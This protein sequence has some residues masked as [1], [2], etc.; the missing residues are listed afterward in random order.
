MIASGDEQRGVRNRG[1]HRGQR[2]E[3]E[4]KALVSSPFAEGE[5]AKFAGWAQRGTG[6]MGLPES[7]VRTDGDVRCSIALMER[8]PIALQQDRHRVGAQ[9]QP[10]GESSG[11]V[12]KAGKG[13][14]RMSQ[15]AVLHQVVE[16]DVGPVSRGAGKRRR[17]QAYKGG[18]SRGAERRINE[19]E[20]YDLRLDFTQGA[21]DS[22]RSAHTADAPTAANVEAIKLRQLRTLVFIAKDRK[23][24]AVSPEFCSKMKSIFAEM[25][26][27]WR[28]GCDQSDT[29]GF[30]GRAIKICAL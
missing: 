17:A 7:A 11:E 24:Y 6:R 8:A 10:G 20:P 25:V 28:K 30:Y 14:I 23:I 18:H 3:E 4:V 22:A 16:R 29:H 19:V 15:I 27:A 9:Q 5:D 12:V 21:Q 26:P 2:F 1:E 13:D